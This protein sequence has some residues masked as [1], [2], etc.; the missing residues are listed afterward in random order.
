[1]RIISIII[2]ATILLI[3]IAFIT[4]NSQIISINYL[5]GK[6]QVYFPLLLILAVFIG[7][8]LMLLAFIPAWLRGKRDIFRLRSEVRQ[9]EVEIKNLRNIPIKDQC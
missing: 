2:W 9:L 6:H 8:V 7:G 5:F 3:S 4:T 1:M